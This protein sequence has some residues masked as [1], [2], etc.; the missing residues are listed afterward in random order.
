MQSNDP[1]L[2]EVRRDFEN[3]GLLLRQSSFYY[4]F[5][6]EIKTQL[7]DEF[8]LFFRDNPVTAEYR[9]HG[10]E[11][12]SGQ[13]ETDIANS[14][15]HIAVDFAD[16]PKF[17]RSLLVSRCSARIRDLWF[18]SPTHLIYTPNPAYSQ[19]LADE[20]A[21]L[22][23]DYNVPKLIQVGECLTG[24]FDFTVTLTCRALSE[25]E[26]D[27][28]SDLVL[29]GL[30]GQVRIRLARIGMN[31]LP[32]T[33]QLGD[34][35]TEPMTNRQVVFAKTITFGIRSEWARNFIYDA[36]VITD[37]VITDVN[38]DPELE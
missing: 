20:A 6:R 11:R 24:R 3:T 31:W 36:P 8:R 27:E 23:E 32:E 38:I 13:F 10:I 14:K 1:G 12:G 2:T 7:V 33:G 25:A 26:L 17:P 34:T 29:H 37:V 19:A 4:G 21:A 22:G 5:A 16:N 30:I 9:W 15:I 35:T 28:I 18:N